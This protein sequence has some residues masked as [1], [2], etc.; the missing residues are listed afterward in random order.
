LTWVTVRSA[1]LFFKPTTLLKSKAVAQSFSA[2][3]TAWPD[4]VKLRNGTDGHK[5]N[6]QLATLVKDGLKI[7]EYPLTSI[8]S[9]LVT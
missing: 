6:V 2:Q 7:A 8:P 5:I 4:V 9:S 3:M 1:G